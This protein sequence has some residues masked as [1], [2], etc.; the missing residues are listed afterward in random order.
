MDKNDKKWTIVTFHH[1]IFSASTGRDNPMLRALWKPLLDHYN[2]DLALQGHDH[3]Y[4]RGAVY[5]KPIV[6]KKEMMPTK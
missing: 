4:A 3:S 2:V 6:V 5:E 1:P